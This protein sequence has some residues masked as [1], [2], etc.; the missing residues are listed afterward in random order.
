MLTMY[1]NTT[2]VIEHK[3][4]DRTTRR[5]VNSAIVRATLRDSDGLTVS[6]AEWPATLSYVSGSKGVYRYFTPADLQ[7]VANAEYTLTIVT[8]DQANHESEVV[9]D[10]VAK[11]Q[12]C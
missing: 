3:V 8:D 12:R 1:L 7:L 9:K 11:V 4:F 2:N 5:P 10:V 6:G